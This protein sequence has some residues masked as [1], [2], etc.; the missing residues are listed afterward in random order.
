MI[1]TGLARDT[2]SILDDH[3]GESY[4]LSPVLKP[5]HA[6]IERNNSLS[7]SLGNAHD[8]L[9]EASPSQKAS[10]TTQQTYKTNGI[11][12]RISSQMS[13]SGS[14]TAFNGQDMPLAKSMPP[15]HNIMDDPLDEAE[16]ALAGA[17]QMLNLLGDGKDNGASGQSYWGRQTS[18][19]PEHKQKRQSNT[20][21]G[22]GDE[23]ASLSLDDEA[24]SLDAVEETLN[25][26]LRMLNAYGDLDED[27]DQSVEEAKDNSQ[28][29][30][31]ARLAKSKQFTE[32]DSP[33]HRPPRNMESQTQTS[34]QALPGDQL[35]TSPTSSQFSGRAGLAD[36]SEASDAGV[37]SST[38][39]DKS[40]TYKITLSG[41]PHSSGNSITSFPLPA[42]SAAASPRSTIPPKGQSRLY[43]SFS[44]GEQCSKG[45]RTLIS[46]WA[47]GSCPKIIRSEKVEESVATCHLD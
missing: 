32:S 41:Q 9:T 20:D 23:M 14:L 12:T 5:G 38:L 2:S 3:D 1:N 40:G 6:K 15:I 43:P 29:A 42:T 39:S 7:P 46:I 24:N 16:E 26:A 33:P 47:D 4:S 45:L 27:I 13:V 37:S 36:S 25:Q 17:L 35:P 19:Q 30:M 44:L 34:G 22:R 10:H 11:D 8:I 18:K 21:I 31:A 28:A